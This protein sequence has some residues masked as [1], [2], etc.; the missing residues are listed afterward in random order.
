MIATPERFLG[1]ALFQTADRGVL[2]EAHGVWPFKKIVVGPEFDRLP[3]D[4]RIAALLHETHH[5]RRF[6]FEIRLLLLPLCWTKWV[7]RI[8][9]RQEFACDKFAADNGFGGEMLALL[10]RVRKSSGSEFY[11]SIEER[12]ERLVNLLRRSVH[13][14][15]A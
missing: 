3:Y 15:A 7:A 8:A 5:C 9:Q 12:C 6:H 13:E 14:V 2:A 11:P 4:E 10:K 1:L